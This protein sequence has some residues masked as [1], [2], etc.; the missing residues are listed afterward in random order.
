M[1]RRGVLGLVVRI[2]FRRA[3]VTGAENVPATGPA[4]LVFNHPNSLVDPL[5]ALAM[6]PRPVVFLAKEPLFRIPVL[7]FLVKSMGS[8]PVYRKMDGADTAQN[9]RTFDKV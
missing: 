7:G 6:S 8:I 2:F 4:L 9:R 1:I 3:V 5:I